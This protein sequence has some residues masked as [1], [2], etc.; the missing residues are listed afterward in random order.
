[1]SNEHLIGPPGSQSAT[2]KEFLSEFLA[3]AKNE[4]RALLLVSSRE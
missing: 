1:M 3:N 2:L 4:K